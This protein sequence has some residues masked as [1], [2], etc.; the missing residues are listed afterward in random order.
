MRAFKHPA[1]PADEK[2]KIHA[3][4]IGCVSRHFT[5]G[6]YAAGTTRRN[7]A[8][9][10]KE[11]YFMSTNLLAA[12]HTMRRGLYLLR[13]C[14]HRGWSAIALTLLLSASLA[15]PV[16][17]ETRRLCDRR[18]TFE[19]VPPSNVPPSLAALSGVWRGTVMM[20]GGSEMCLSVVVKEVFADG[21]VHLLMTWN[22]SVGGRDDINNYVG[23]GEALHWPNKV[24]NGEIRIDS[25]TRY[26][27][28][29]YYYVLAIP[30]DSN[31]H[32]MEGRWM[33]DTHPQPVVLYREKR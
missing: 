18:V 2:M 5:P 3:G 7:F 19:V 22:L 28:R 25:R 33:T 9:E 1:S 11:P 31:P 6:T 26:N 21:T 12:A 8:T 32:V 17:A 20:A 13:E 23:M 30:T 15:F 14:S 27:G 4:Y 10:T 24:E 29:H 16:Q